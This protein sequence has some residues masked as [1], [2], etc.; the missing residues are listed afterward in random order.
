MHFLCELLDLLRQLFRLLLVTHWLECLR[1]QVIT[2]YQ[3]DKDARY[4]QQSKNNP[5][6]WVRLSSIDF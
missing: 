5:T 1:I 6:D 3:I 4:K 2:T